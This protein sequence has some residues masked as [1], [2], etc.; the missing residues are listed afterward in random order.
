M[1]D[2]AWFWMIPCS[3]C[4]GAGCGRSAVCREP[5]QTECSFPLGVEASTSY[6]D[7]EIQLRAGQ[8]LLLYTDGITEA[9]SPSGELLGEDQLL[10]AFTGTQGSAEER[11]AQ[12]VQCIRDHE[13]GLR[14]TDDQTMLVIQALA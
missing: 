1:S 12:L 9:R 7:T 4:A 10:R 8:T 5:L 3:Y 11:L 6:E 14:P 13:A 2:P